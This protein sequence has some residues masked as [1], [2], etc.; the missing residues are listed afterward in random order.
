MEAFEKFLKGARFM[1]GDGLHL[2]IALWSRGVS[3]SQLAKRTGLNAA[4]ISMAANGR[5]NLDEGQK[6]RIAQALKS[7]KEEIF[8]TNG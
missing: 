4:I 6:A 1:R 7:T 8:Q 3:Q 5:Y 2:K